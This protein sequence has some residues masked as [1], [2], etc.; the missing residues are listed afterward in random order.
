M[1]TINPDS[2]NVRQRNVVDD[3]VGVPSTTDNPQQD[4]TD[5]PHTEVPKWFV[6]VIKNHSEIKV[7]DNL[8]QKGF[9]CFVPVIISEKTW[10]N[11]RKHKSVT[12]LLSAKI[13]IRCTEEQR[14][15]E[16]V[17]LPYISRFM[18]DRS[19][20]TSRKLMV[21]PDNDMEAFKKAVECSQGEIT[22]WESTLVTGDMVRITKGAMEGL[23]GYIERTTSGTNF[24]IKIG[25][26][27]Y[28][29]VTVQK[30]SF[31]KIPKNKVTREQ[32][33]LSRLNTRLERQNS[34]LLR[35]EEKLEE[36]NRI[37]NHRK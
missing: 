21:I 7:S 17:K 13:F 27:G 34:R 16:I 20:G 24:L 1:E 6:A 32:Q 23:V 22:V 30:G 12:P 2:E 18:V 28:A 4:S 29:S 15:D 8:T 36:R 37:N 9:E 5:S 25:T 31:E 14:M 10:N 35:I 19:S 26:F 11:G 33:E 3:A